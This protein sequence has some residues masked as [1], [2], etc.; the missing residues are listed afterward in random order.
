MSNPT[1]VSIKS[2]PHAEGYTF[3]VTGSENTKFNCRYDGKD[4]RL[5]IYIHGTRVSE[6]L[7]LVHGL[8]HKK[9]DFKRKLYKQYSEIKPKRLNSIVFTSTT[10]YKFTVKEDSDVDELMKQ[11]YR[12]YRY[13]VHDEDNEDVIVARERERIRKA[14]EQNAT[15]KFGFAQ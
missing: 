7:R 8:L 14:M 4:V 12:F 13:E 15:Q 3:C 9:S 11:Y 1:M 6:V 2:G 10:G 5:S